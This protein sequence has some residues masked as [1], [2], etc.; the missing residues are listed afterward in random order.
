MYV[1]GPEDFLSVRMYFLGFVI[2]PHFDNEFI[3][4]DF[5]CARPT[6]ELGH[7]GAGLP[8]NITKCIGG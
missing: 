1:L 3:V 5:K 8:G 4:G 7:G 6:V 2:L